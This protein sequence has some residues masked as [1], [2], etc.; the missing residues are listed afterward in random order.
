[1]SPA[2]Q[3]LQSYFIMQKLQRPN[4]WTS[5][6]QKY[7]E[8]SSLL[9]TSPLITD[10]TI[11]PPTLEQKQ[12][13]TGFNVNIVYGNLKTENSPDYAHKPQ[14]NCTFMNLASGQAQV[15]GPKILQAEVKPLKKVA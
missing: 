2:L 8:F 4:S 14:R 12:V 3:V 5:L 15:E 13:E 1:M 9:F 6:V 10:F 11:F 7:K